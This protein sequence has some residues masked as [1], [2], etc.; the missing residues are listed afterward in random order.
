MA[1]CVCFQKG[2]FL[3][4][5]SFMRW[6]QILQVVEL[7]S[8]T[9]YYFPGDKRCERNTTFFFLFSSLPHLSSSTDTKCH[10]LFCTERQAQLIFFVLSTSCQNI[11]GNKCKCV[12]YF[13]CILSYQ[14]DVQL[15]T[16][17]VVRH[18]SIT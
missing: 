15:C 16:L 17:C 10:L 13:L 3:E 7:E 8:T 14:Y 4:A 1:P 2:L 12:R 6:R 9:Q 5:F 11:I 18:Y